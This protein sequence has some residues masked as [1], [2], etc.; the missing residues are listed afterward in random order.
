MSDF[1]DPAGRCLVVTFPGIHPAT[2]L[3]GMLFFPER[4]PGLQEVHEKLCGLEGC[5]AMT[6]RGK[7]KYDAFSRLH[8]AITMYDTQAGERPTF[9]CLTRDMFERLLGHPRPM[10]QLHCADRSVGGHFSDESR[11]ADDRSDILTAHRHAVDLGRYVE[12]L[13]LY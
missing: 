8:Q 12:I 5:A 2:T 1:P 13:A 6:A 3:L 7:N 11:E 9:A 4:R 10:F